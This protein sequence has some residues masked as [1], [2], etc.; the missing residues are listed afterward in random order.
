MPVRIRASST[1]A[2]PAG[3]RRPPTTK[4]AASTHALPPSGRRNPPRDRSRRLHPG[5]RVRLSTSHTRPHRTAIAV[6]ARG[7]GYLFDLRSGRQRRPENHRPARRWLRVGATQLLTSRDRVAKKTSG[8]RPAR[9]RGRRSVQP[10]A[11]AYTRPVLLLDP[12]PAGASPHPRSSSTM[13]LAALP[14]TGPRS[15]TEYLHDH[16]P[17]SAPTRT[18]PSGPSPASAFRRAFGRARSTSPRTH[19]TVPRHI[20]GASAPSNRRRPHRPRSRRCSS[21]NRQLSCSRTG[22]G[23]DDIARRQV[24]A[25]PAS[26]RQLQHQ[27]PSR[28]SSFTAQTSNTTCSDRLIDARR[29]GVVGA[30]PRASPHRP[31]THQA[32]RIHHSLPSGQVLDADSR[33]LPLPAIAPTRQHRGR[34]PLNGGQTIVSLRRRSSASAGPSPRER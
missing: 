6:G 17:W 15:M 18:G 5:P 31:L 4:L 24:P 9:V 26:S 32:G 23:P 16:G 2:N 34:S 28:G 33:A 30:R 25:G 27:Q 20:P 1:T 13:S 7:L 12:W 11:K 19:A 22:A 10:S 3:Y 21:P 14:C 8:P 29:C